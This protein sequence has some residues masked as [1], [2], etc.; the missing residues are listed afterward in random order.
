MVNQSTYPPYKESHAPWRSFV[1]F[2]P[3]LFFA[4]ALDTQLRL[5]PSTNT[6]T[7]TRLQRQQALKCVIVLLGRR[8]CRQQRVNLGRIRLLEATE[9]QHPPEY[10]PYRINAHP[11]P[12]HI[13][14]SPLRDNQ[15]LCMC[16]YARHTPHRNLHRQHH[17]HNTTTSASNIHFLFRGP[18]ALHLCTAAWQLSWRYSFEAIQE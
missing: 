8:T 12:V 14:A 18:R 17:H 16:A 4:A 9:H 10:V 11:K 1:S 3:P 6:T 13:H 5:G 7:S 15:L 2:P